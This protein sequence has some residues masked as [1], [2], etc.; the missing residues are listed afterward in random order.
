MGEV[1]ACVSS[2]AGTIGAC[3]KSLGGKGVVLV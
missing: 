3:V 1:G 2:L